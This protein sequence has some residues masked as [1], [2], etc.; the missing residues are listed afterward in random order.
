MMLNVPDGVTVRAQNKRGYNVHNVIVV[1]KH[2][3]DLLANGIFKPEHIT[4]ETPYN[5]QLDQYKQAIY[6]I[7]QTPFGQKLKIN[8]IHR[9]TGDS[10]Q[11]G[12]NE[13]FYFDSV[14]AS[15]S[16]GGIDSSKNI[17]Y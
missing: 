12:E 4:I 9:Q 14:V 5:A 13:A 10:S 6:H 2:V 3:E 1:V 15:R 16:M 8:L 11:G 17:E 7:S